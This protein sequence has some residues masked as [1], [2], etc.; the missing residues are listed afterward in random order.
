MCGICGLVG[1][2]NNN[3]L[4]SKNISSMASLLRHRGPDDEGYIAISTRSREVTPL[5][6]NDSQIQHPRIEQFTG[7]ADVYLAHRRLSILD[8]S[9]AGHQPMSYDHGHLW[10]VYNGELYNHAEL[11]RELQ[12][13]GHHFRTRTDTEVLLAAYSQWGEECLDRFDGMWAFVLYDKRRNILFGSRDR[14]GVKPLYIFRK[15]TFFAFASEIKAFYPLPDFKRAVNE[16]AVFDYLAFGCERWDDGSTFFSEVEEISAS[17][18]FRFDLATK[19]FH[20]FSYYT[21]PYNDGS[22]WESFDEK[23]AVEHVENI[24]ELLFRSVRQHLA[25]DV[26]V[27]TCL[28]GG[29]DSSSLVGIVA[30]I[31]GQE[32]LTQ[33]GL[34]PKAFTACYDDPRI[35]ESIWAKCV[36]EN[37]KADW[38][39]VYPQG[40]ELLRDLEDL[41]YVQDFPF[42]STSIYAQYRVMKLA[43]E[44][45]VTVLLDGQGGDELF[46]GYTPYYPP[47]FTEMLRH[48]AWTSLAREWSGLSNS[49]MGRKE[50]AV[51]ICKNMVKGFCP[52]GL[53]KA[54]WDQRNPLIEYLLPSFRTKQY[55]CSIE[56]YMAS[57]PNIFSLTRMLH[58]LMSGF[59]QMLLRYEDRN[60]MRF[61]I[62]SRTPFADDRQLIE[63]VFAMSSVYKIHNGYSKWLLREAAK[64]ILPKQIYHRVDKIG[65]ATPE[66]QWLFPHR[67][68]FK[69]LLIDYAGE[70]IDGAKLQQSWDEFLKRQP[71]TGVTPLWRFVNLVM[72]MKMISRS[73]CGN[74]S[75]KE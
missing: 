50:V 53:K 21:L 7:E 25:A 35:D 47:F 23:K 57:C 29:I 41:V 75:S 67:E 8:L 63:A 59:L 69:K 46:T 19:Q 27:G 62:E 48:G 55:N 18:A 45:G 73:G 32:T 74:L 28:S 17:G 33:V 40:D 12:S 3:T 22:H 72:W 71:A 6:G 13:L 39:K 43:R 38:Y 61:H 1:C 56:H 5:S 42:G 70:Y 4:Y 49:P 24:R 60:S 66:Y 68:K 58:D 10:V 52:S 54:L 14:F 31:L 11:R 9:S 2:D 64:P 51:G 44:S 37:S 36:A 20:L 16:E 15:D 30:A 26:P 34:H 65:F